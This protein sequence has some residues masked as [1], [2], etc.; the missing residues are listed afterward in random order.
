MK[1]LD[2][3]KYTKEHEWILVESDEAV[4]GITD[5]AQKELGDVA[6]VDID[7][8]GETLSQGERFGS[9][10]AVKAVSELFMPVSGTVLAVNPAL[11]AAPETI[12]KDPYGEGWIIRIKM[13]NPDELKELMSAAQYDKLITE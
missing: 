5:F 4:V 6:F 13:S 1:T 7:T 8:E 10:E 2:N 9:V 3:L 12:N 11:E